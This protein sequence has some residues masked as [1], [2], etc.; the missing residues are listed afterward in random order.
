MKALKTLALFGFLKLC[1]EKQINFLA[2]NKELY[3][4]FMSVADE[5][6]KYKLKKL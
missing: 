3:I 4:E 2:E 6:T 1:T 5:E